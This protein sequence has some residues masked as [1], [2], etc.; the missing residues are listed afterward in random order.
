[1]SVFVPIV[2]PKCSTGVAWLERNKKGRAVKP[3]LMGRVRA[4]RDEGFEAVHWSA[5]GS[6]DATDEGIMR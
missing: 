6:P 4:L 5:I 1:M 3:G 2:F